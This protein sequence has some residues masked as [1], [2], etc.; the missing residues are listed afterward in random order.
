M[1]SFI[2]SLATTMTLCTVIFISICNADETTQAITDA[3]F[4][5]DL[6]HLHTFARSSDGYNRAYS[7]YRQAQLTFANPNEQT[8]SLL[9]DA[10]TILKTNN[11]GES[12]VL[13]AAVY[14]LI[15]GASPDRAQTLAPRV[16]LLLNQGEKSEPATRARALLIKGINRFYTPPAFGGG[17]D[18]AFALLQQAALQFQENQDNNIQDSIAW[19]PVETQIWLGKVEASLGNKKQAMHYYQNALAINPNCS[20]V[21]FYIKQL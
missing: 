19:G 12:Q 2:R 13:L 14:N 18:I 6:K 8:R 4:Q 1:T 20:W 15:M 9:Q 3:A 11:D 5:N 17:T 21:E 10:A 16:E 7:F